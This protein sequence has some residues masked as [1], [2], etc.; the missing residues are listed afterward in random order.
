MVEKG[1]YFYNIN[2]DGYKTYCE[3]IYYLQF[4]D[5]NGR[6]SNCQFGFRHKQ[7]LLKFLKLV[8]LY[9]VYLL[10]FGKAFDVIPHN[11]LLNKLYFYG[12]RGKLYDW[13]ESYLSERSQFVEI[14]NIQSDTKPKKHK[15]Q[16]KIVYTMVLYLDQFCSLLIFMT[17][18]GLLRNCFL[19]YI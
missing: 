10:T 1:A 4:L 16:K 2:Y 12:I 5:A 7:E 6:L 19:F 13:F 17:F 3:Q 11:T 9:A 18:L 14:Q 8:K 15:K